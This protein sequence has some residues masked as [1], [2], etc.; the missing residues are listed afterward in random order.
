MRVVRATAWLL[1]APVLTAL[2]F[3]LAA[4]GLVLDGGRGR[5]AHAVARAWGRAM[6][7]A[8]GARLV[9]EGERHLDAAE[10]RVLVANHASYLDIPALLA[11][12]PGQLRFLARSSLIW[13]PFIGWYLRL[14]GHFSVDRK[15]PRQALA[16]VGRMAE[17]MKRRGLSPLVFPEGT[18]SR[19]GRLAALKAGALALP[20]QVRAPV[21]P[22]AV[23]G[24][25]DVLPKGAWVPR[26]SGTVTVRFGEALGPEGYEGSAGRKALA[27]ATRARLLALGVEDGTP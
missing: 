24:T 27:D 18:R 22:I 14:A 9:V 6:L 20:V 26:R 16:L 8:A 19:D 13:L 7:F 15:D 5:G 25:H 23:L 4:L 3:T 10:A 21:Q 2:G 17:R 12:F 11:A 1:L